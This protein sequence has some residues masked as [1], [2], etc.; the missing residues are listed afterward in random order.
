MEHGQV[1]RTKN[2]SMVSLA[3]TANLARSKL[4]PILLALF[5]PFLVFWTRFRQAWSNPTLCLPRH[6]YDAFI[7]RTGETSFG[8]WVR[9]FRQQL[10]TH[11][12]WHFHKKKAW[13]SKPWTNLL[14]GLKTI[15][16]PK[17]ITP[18]DYVAC[19]SDTGDSKLKCHTIGGGGG[20]FWSNFFS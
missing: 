12:D 3:T 16:S 17:H 20:A 18:P 19:W 5:T 13:N 4:N 14:N 8:R 2:E 15:L 11:R 10:S 9:I 7:K 6:Y 1:F